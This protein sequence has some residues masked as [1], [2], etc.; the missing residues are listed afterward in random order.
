MRIRFLALVWALI[1]LSGFLPVSSVS[2]Q[3]TVATDAVQWLLGRQQP[4]GSF[5]G[6]DA[7]ASAD[8]ILALAA[9]NEAPQVRQQAAAYLATQAQSYATGSPAAAGKTVLAALAA[10]SD[11]RAFGGVDL[12]QTIQAT[13]NQNGQ[14]GATPTDHAY[15]LL[16][17]AAAGQAIPPQALAAARDSQLPDGGWSYDGAEATGSDTNTTALMLQALVAANA[18]TDIRT[19]AVA[20]LRSQQNGDGGFP[21]SQTSS[22]GNA[23]DANSTA[24]TVQ[25][26]IAA[27]TDPATLAKGGN[28]P[29]DALASFQNQNGAFRYQLAIPDDNDLAT[30][31]AIP[32]LLGVPFPITTASVPQQAAPAMPATAGEEMAWWPLVALGAF[33]IGAGLHLRRRMPC[34]R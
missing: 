15:A 7:G 10:G 22:F 34:A 24:L 28:T 19:S 16:A 30:A 2:A 4:D 1:A 3:N 12:L 21:Y 25:A 31:Q 13:Y 20:Y 33:S 6:F 14:F 26:L 8:A 5:P 32:A 11:P 9:A 29:L 27:G 17:L 23:S 18:P